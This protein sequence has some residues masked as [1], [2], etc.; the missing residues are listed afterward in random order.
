M[1][2][3]WK[4]VDELFHAALEQSEQ[5]RPA[6]LAAKC[7]AD[8]SL[9]VAVERLLRAHQSAGSFLN[10]AAA[11]AV[12]RAIACDTESIDDSIGPY[13]R[14]REI[15][16]G[17]MGAVYLAERADE[18]FRKVVAIKV[19]KRGMDTD[20]MLRRFHDERQILADLEHAN[21]A[22]LLDGGT[23]SDGRPYVVMDYVDGDP[24]D[25][26]CD[27]RRR[28]LDL[29]LALFLQLC[30]AVSYAHQRLVIHCDIKPSNVVV[31]ND[32]VPKLLDFGI[33]RLMRPGGPE[34]GTGNTVFGFRGM[35]PEYAS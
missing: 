22:R 18:Q 13:R 31:T 8:T 3:D 11:D 30:A 20:A 28:G 35:T 15:G 12:V 1:S 10:T 29:R 21:I 6:F 34:T 16:R 26:Y 4:I 14:I 33:A 17:G 7:G 5:T 9:R 25:R 19:I 32:G 2:P 27:D 23:T 24:L